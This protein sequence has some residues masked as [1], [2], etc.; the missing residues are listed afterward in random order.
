MKDLVF[1]RY[2]YI[3]YLNTTFCIIAEAYTPYPH[4]TWHNIYIY[5]YLYS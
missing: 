5:N 1:Y 4:I 2:F 3:E